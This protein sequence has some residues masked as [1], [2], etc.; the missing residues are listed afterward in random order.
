M[1]RAASGPHLRRGRKC[2]FDAGGS[3]VR[4]RAGNDVATMFERFQANEHYVDIAS[5]RRRFPGIHWHHF[6]SWAETADWQ[7][8]LAP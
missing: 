6:A 8:L 7:H 5:L 4:Q 2:R 3:G 1:S